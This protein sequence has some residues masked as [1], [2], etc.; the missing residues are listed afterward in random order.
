[1]AQANKLGRRL[2]QGPP[3]ERVRGRTS[4]PLPG[5][6]GDRSVDL[7][8]PRALEV[9]PLQMD[10]QVV[11]HPVQLQLLASTPMLFAMWTQPVS[12]T[13]RVTPASV[14]DRRATRLSRAA[15]P[16]RPWRSVSWPYQRSLSSSTSGSENRRR[17]VSTSMLVV[18]D[19]TG[20]DRYMNGLNEMDF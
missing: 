9:E 15:R 1:M 8:S 12:G 13:A 4:N 14:C 11:R 5:W 3:G 2:S 20:T 18:P 16:V 10:D 7:F 19:G 6:K 17:Q